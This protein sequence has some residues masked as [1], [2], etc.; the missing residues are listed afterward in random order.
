MVPLIILNDSTPLGYRL[1]IKSCSGGGGISS[2]SP[3]VVAV[4]VRP[5][6]RREIVSP[7]LP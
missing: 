7:A 2:S 3:V 1:V 4:R 5:L 6:S